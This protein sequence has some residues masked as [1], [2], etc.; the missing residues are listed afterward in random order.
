MVV[1]E[2]PNSPLVH[3]LPWTTA[4]PHRAFLEKGRTCTKA[5][6][7]KDNEISGKNKLFFEVELCF[8]LTWFGEV[9]KKRQA[10]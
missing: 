2:F 4:T 5:Q 7:M 9:G 6:R 1:R 3:L 8:S 10:R